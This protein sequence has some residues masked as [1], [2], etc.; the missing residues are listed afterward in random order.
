MSSSSEDEGSSDDVS[1]DEDDE[2]GEAEAEDAEA[3]VA[4]WGVGALAANPEEEIPLMDE[5]KR[6]EHP[7]PHPHRV[8]TVLLSYRYYI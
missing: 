6:C 7:H 8:H 1:G 4:E 2:G 3:L 5:T